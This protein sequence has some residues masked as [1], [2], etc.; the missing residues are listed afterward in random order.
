MSYSE[1]DLAKMDALGIP[2]GANVTF[3]DMDAQRPAPERVTAGWTDTQIKGQPLSAI[4]S[5]L[6]SNERTLAT[7]E[8]Q[9][10]Q[11]RSHIAGLREVRQRKLE[12]GGD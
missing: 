11:L 8:E 1:A 5:Q 7:L 9:T 10:A 3:I 2:R 12:L 6:S 4:E